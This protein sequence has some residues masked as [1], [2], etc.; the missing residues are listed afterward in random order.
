M[1][2]QLI[3]AVVVVPRHRRV[4]DRPVH[5]FDRSVC[6]RMVWLGQPML[7]TVGP[8]DR[9]EPHLA[10]R[11]AVSVSKLPCELDAVVHCAAGYFPRGGENGVDLVRHSL[12]QVF[13]DF[14][15]SLA[16]G[17]LDALDHGELT[18]SVNGTREI[19]WDAKNLARPTWPEIS[20]FNALD[21]ERRFKCFAF[22]FGACLPR[23]YQW[24]NTHLSIV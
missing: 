1:T 17:C 15:S 6:L 14:R 9:I 8:A 20:D 5:P 23:R 22:R 18:G 12:K 10:E 21:D 2:E 24:G 11:H 19:K 7:E 3:V 16:I 4:P 13:K